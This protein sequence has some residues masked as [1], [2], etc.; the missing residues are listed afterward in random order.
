M[1]YTDFFFK[2][3]FVIQFQEKLIKHYEEII[4][5]SGLESITRRFEEL[6]QFRFSYIHF[7]FFIH[8]IRII[9]I[10]SFQNLISMRV[11]PSSRICVTQTL[12]SFI[13]KLKLFRSVFFQ[14]FIWMVFQTHFSK[15]FCNFFISCFLLN[16]QQFIITLFRKAFFS[17]FITLRLTSSTHFWLHTLLIIN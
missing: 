17:I 2:F 8:V 13:D 15:P 12:I 11:I 7:I 6:R 10:L 14:I 16:S 5:C 4:W 1:L 3:F 9:S